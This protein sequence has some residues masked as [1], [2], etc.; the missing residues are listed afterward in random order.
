MDDTSLVSVNS[1]SSSLDK[2]LN[3]V[4]FPFIHIKLPSPT[5]RVSILG[6]VLGSIYHVFIKDWLDVFPREQFLFIRSEEYFNN[7]T[8]VIME[9]VNFLEMSKS[10]YFLISYIPNNGFAMNFD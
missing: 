8:A 6:A 4:L 7:R 2:Y 10:L 5:R 9:I 3:V 1:V